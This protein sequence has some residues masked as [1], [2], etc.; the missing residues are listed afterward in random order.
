MLQRRV[1]AALAKYPP[2]YLVLAICAGACWQF[3]DWFRPGLLMSGAAL[4][5]ALILLMAWPFFALR[6]PGFLDRLVRPPGEQSDE[7]AKRVRKLEDELER[8]DA[9]QASEQLRL[10]RQKL[11]KL[12]AVLRHRLDEGE[13]T[14]GRYLATAEQVYLASLDNLHEVVVALTSLS[15]MDA[16]YLDKRVIEIERDG[17]TDSERAELETIHE[18]RA[19]MKQQQAKVEQLLSENERAMTV[20][21]NTSAALAGTRTRSGHAT[22]SADD[23]IRQLEELAG[24]AG[25]YAS[26][27]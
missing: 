16:A 23:A 25:R 4:A 20:L 11:E 21:D 1:F 19:L 14:Y 5:V 22:V 9:E 13:V 27:N 17:I 3:Y 7:A 24:R 18:R 10:L 15:G 6:D 12:T 2:S 26:R 8:L